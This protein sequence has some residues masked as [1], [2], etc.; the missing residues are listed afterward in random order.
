ML[1]WLSASALSA[2]AVCAFT[3]LEWYAAR[4]RS[5]LVRGALP[6]LLDL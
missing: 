3:T 5:A 4:L 6:P 1:L 2:N